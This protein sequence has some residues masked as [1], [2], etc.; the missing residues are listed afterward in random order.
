[1]NCV[2]VDKTIVFCEPVRKMSVRRNDSVLNRLLTC[3][4]HL[5]HKKNKIFPKNWLLIT[6]ITV[7]LLN[8]CF[9]VSKE[10]LHLCI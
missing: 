7:C 6:V 1:M 5:M 9:M 10:T 2:V 4:L 3:L 8:F